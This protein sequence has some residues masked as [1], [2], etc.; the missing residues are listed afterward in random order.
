[1][2]ASRIQAMADASEIWITED[3]WSYPGVQDLLAPYP[4]EERTAEFHGI[5]QPMNVVRIGGRAAAEQR[6]PRPS[7][8]PM[9]QAARA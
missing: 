5:D 3:V 4:A 1:N 6:S 7:G 2:I 8:E 9:S